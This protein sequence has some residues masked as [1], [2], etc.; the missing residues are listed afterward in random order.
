[1]KGG[2]TMSVMPTKTKAMFARSNLQIFSLRKTRAK[3]TVKI[4]AVAVTVRRVKVRARSKYSQITEVSQRY[5]QSTKSWTQNQRPD[6]W[7]WFRVCT[8]TT[9]PN[10][11]L[12]EVDGA[13]HNSGWR[14]WRSPTRIDPPRPNGNLKK[15]S[16]PC[17]I[18]IHAS[19]PNQLRNYA[20]E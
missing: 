1:M 2:L 10:L 3:T 9:L 8:S 18:Y 15:P 13:K 16:A 7:M 11:Y 14:G 19:T 12:P 17:H 5:L 20:S 4:G 6:T